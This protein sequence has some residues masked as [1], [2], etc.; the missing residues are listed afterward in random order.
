MIGCI[1]HLKND[2][3]DD[4]NDEHEAIN[5]DKY[6]VRAEEY[7][8]YHQQQKQQF[9]HSTC[10]GAIHYAGQESAQESFQNNIKPLHYQPPC[11]RNESFTKAVCGTDETVYPNRSAL[12]TSWLHNNLENGF[13]ISAKRRTSFCNAVHASVNIKEVRLFIIFFYLLYFI[14]P[15]FKSYHTVSLHHSRL[16]L[17]NYL[18]FFL[19]LFILKTLYY[20]R[21]KIW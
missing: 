3:D 7:Q 18:H 8:L 2:D 9:D 10:D 6:F 20:N 14:N 15:F 13:Y 5:W 19:L 11:N 17:L 4:K 21:T 12:K 1:G 16:F